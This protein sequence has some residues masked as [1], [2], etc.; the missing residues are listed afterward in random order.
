MPIDPSITAAAVMAA[1]NAYNTYATG[2]SNKKT[3]DYNAEMYR[4]QRFD[5]L[6]DWNMQNEY[7]SPKAQMSRLREAG[8]N[9][10][11]IYGTGSVATGQSAPVQQVQSKPYEHKAASVELTGIVDA[12]M[13]GKKIDLLRA[14]ADLANANARLQ[15]SKGVGQDI[16]NEVADQTKVTKVEKAQA[17][18]AFT[19]R[20]IQV[21]LDKNE[22]EQKQNP[23]SISEQIARIALM[24]AQ[25]KNMKITQSE[26]LQRIENL[27]TQKKISDEQL[28]LLLLGKPM[29]GQGSMT[30]LLYQ[31]LGD[32]NN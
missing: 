9:P 4:R 21:M 5:S 2:R 7:N 11:L 15:D 8:L 16:A 17:D 27:K 30:G 26:V 19:Q 24:A 12:L 32:I 1:G 20:A 29:P 28:R 18:L 31:L 6:A 22:R 13:L 25:A 23:V 10:H 3:R 14:Q